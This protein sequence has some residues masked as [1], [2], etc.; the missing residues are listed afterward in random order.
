MDRH[1]GRR[2]RFGYIGC[3]GS[4][5]YIGKL[6]SCVLKSKDI[7]GFDGQI[8]P[9]V[10]GCYITCYDRSTIQKFMKCIFR[11]MALNFIFEES[12][13]NKYMIR[14]SISFGNVIEADSIINCSKEFKSKTNY[15]SGIL[16]GSPLARANQSE[17]RAAPFG[18]WIDEIAR[19]FAPTNGKTIRT[20]FWDWWSYPS[21][22]EEVDDY[23]D[24]LENML[25]EDLA[26]YFSWCK[27]NHHKLL[28]PVDAL[29][30]HRSIA[31]QYFPS[32]PPPD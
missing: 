14:G 15:T 29:E 28:Y 27:R 20:T 26:N 1:N 8:Y 21:Q 23:C 11:L 24:D 17:S 7:T 3:E 30:R 25:A 18:I 5:I 12:N 10:D 22:I 4:N 16:F 9:F 2:K 13:D 31:S 6:H 32:W 19:H